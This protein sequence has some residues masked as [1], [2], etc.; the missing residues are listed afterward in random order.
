M[1]NNVYIYYYNN[2]IIMCTKDH[3]LYNSIYVKCEQQ[4]K[5][6][7]AK[8]RVVVAQGSEDGSTGR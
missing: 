8:S 2:C 4:T 3:I 5:S 6:I 7:Q 1:Y